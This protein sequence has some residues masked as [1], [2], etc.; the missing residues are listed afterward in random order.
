MNIVHVEDKTTSSLYRSRFRRGCLM[1]IILVLLMAPGAC[2]SKL[3]SGEA[4]TKGGVVY[5]IGA[6]HPFTGV[7]AGKGYVDWWPYK[8]LFERTY[9]NGILH[10]TSRYWYENGQLASV[11]PYKNGKLNGPLIQY[12]ENGNKKLMIDYVDGLR[13]GRRGEIFWARDGR[14]QPG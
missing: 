13:G 3:P 7:V 9:K 1:S 10:G 12:Y 5:K 8:C 2:S 14:I 11:E 4:I 6:T